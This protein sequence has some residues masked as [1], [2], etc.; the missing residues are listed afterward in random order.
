MN[1]SSFILQNLDAI[2]AEWDSF[3]RTQLPA[4]Q[5]MSETD[6]RDH[7]RQVLQAAAAEMDTDQNA[8]EQAE[9][10]K[11][12][13]PDEDQPSSPA[14][15]HG[16][17]RQLSGFTFSQLI[18]EF[19][20][21]RASVLRLWLAQY[22]ACNEDTFTQMVRFNETIDQAL[23]QS[24][25]TFTHNA[26]HA[27]ETFLAIL[28]HD[29]RTPL[30]TIAVSGDLLTRG[31]VGTEQTKQIGAKV[32]RNA[33]IMSSMVVDLLEY[34][35][36]QLGAELPIEK[37]EA[38]VTE[39]CRA[40]CEDSRAAYPD[41]DFE[42]DAMGDTHGC[43]DAIRLQQLFTNLLTNAAQYRSKEFPVLVRVRG[44]DDGIVVQVK[45]RGP[46]IP[47]DAL[48]AIF[49][50]L[51]RLSRESHRDGRPSTSLGLG[52][53]IARQVTQAHGGTIDAQSSTGEGTVFTVRL[54]R[55]RD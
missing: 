35:R 39:V 40:S 11:G 47:A 29:L 6:L 42:L 36:T 25:E 2:L 10:S 5:S 54:P 3:A 15:V 24:T 52:L 30:S 32:K 31:G 23:A 17:L 53:F 46:I 7:A 49:D 33:A 13:A 21:L 50:P 41:C 45:N 12:L 14:S 1:L 16:A 9:K 18:A 20:A 28:G 26:N 8:R 27:R 38:D 43:F 44:G 48:Q 22:P 37:A 55:G 4:A 51:V 34:S 19:R